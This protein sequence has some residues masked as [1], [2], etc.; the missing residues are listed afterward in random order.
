M[1]DTGNGATIAFGTSGFTGDIISISG[2][3][4]T[5]ETIEV[6]TLAHTGRKRYIVDDLVEI[7][8]VT[9]T[10]YSDAVVPDMGLSLIHI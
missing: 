7:G 8:E 1:A 4:V 3:E 9:V 6:T 5:K 2:L 10:C